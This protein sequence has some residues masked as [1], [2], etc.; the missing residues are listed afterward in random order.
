ML[1]VGIGPGDD[2]HVQV[3][4]TD[5]GVGIPPENLAKIF[6]YGFTTRQDGHGFGLHSGLKAATDLGGRLRAHSDGPGQGAKFTLELP[7]GAG[8]VSSPVPGGPRDE[9][10]GTKPSPPLASRLHELAGSS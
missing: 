10:P 4:V 1:V 2:G 5:N 8:T 7:L 3:S 6:T 9:E